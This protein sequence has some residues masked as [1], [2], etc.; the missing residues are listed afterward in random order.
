VPDAT[1]T[2]TDTGAPAVQSSGMVMIGGV[3]FTAVPNAQS[4]T[5]TNNDVFTV[6]AAGFLNNSS[7]TQT[8]NV[9]ATLQFQNSSTASGGATPVTYVNNSVMLFQDTS[10][11][12][13][14]LI[15]NG[16]ILQFFNAANA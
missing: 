11:A 2:F 8:F 7:N 14:A 3:V 16:G 6:T 9:A 12:G 4:Y 5:I 1:A 15:T 13:N 10:S